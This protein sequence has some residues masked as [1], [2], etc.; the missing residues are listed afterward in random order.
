MNAL[1]DLFENAQIDS[2]D[3]L[4]S[5]DVEHC[6]KV[7]QNH[8][9]LIKQLDA[10]E[11]GLKE[12]ASK[13]PG[14]NTSVIKTSGR[15]ARVYDYSYNSKDVKER[16]AF[17]EKYGLVYIANSRQEL[18]DVYLRQIIMYFN[19]KYNLDIHETEFKDEHQYQWREIV[20]YILSKMGAN[21]TN[22]GLQRLISD[23]RKQI[24]AYDERDPFLKNNVITFPRF[25]LGDVNECR[26]DSRNRHT[27]CLLLSLSY[28]EN[29]TVDL[30]EGILNLFKSYGNGKYNPAPDNIKTIEGFRAYKN[31]K[32]EIKFRTPGYAAKHF[33]MFYSDIKG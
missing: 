19:N 3:M 22:A 10:W 6:E 12:L 11:G 27:R 31:Y 30:D 1:V 5:K 7:H 21:L 29:T 23:Y 14:Y 2:I 15:K 9:L 25:H 33:Q 32:L 17:T 13:I 26:G 24:L 8:E 4:S 18:R 20:D 28:L 16:Y